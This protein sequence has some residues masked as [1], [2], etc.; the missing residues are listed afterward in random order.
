MR[1]VPVHG[2]SSSMG[3][4]KSRALLVFNAFTGLDQP[5]KSKQRQED[6]VGHM[7]DT[8][9]EVMDVFEV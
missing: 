2:N 3:E 8:Y 7:G 1:Y 5:T 9:D 6:S 4:Q